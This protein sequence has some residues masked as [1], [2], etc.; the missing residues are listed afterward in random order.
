MHRLAD[1][2]VVPHQAHQPFGEVP[3]GGHR[4]QAG[5]VS[6]DEHGLFLKHAVQH[7]PGALVS[8]DSQG[9]FVFAV[10]VAGPHD[11]DGEEIHVIGFHQELFAQGLFPGILPVGIVQRDGFADEVVSRRFLVGGG[12]GDEDVLAGDAGK[13]ADIP[14]SLLP[15][16]GDELHH[17]I[18]LLSL[19]GLAHRLSIVD[20]GQQRPGLRHQVVLTAPVKQ[21]EIPAFLDEQ[22]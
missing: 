10:G 18:K 1:G 2:V 5:A 7:L 8:V 16:V 11:G 9:Q 3:G 13:E 19:K 15:V 22:P 4:P 21:G 17:R 12:G 20:I 6:R 14:E